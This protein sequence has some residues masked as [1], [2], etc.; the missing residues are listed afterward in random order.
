MKV[1]GEVIRFWNSWSLG[2]G[3]SV[4]K[5]MKSGFLSKIHESRGS[6]LKFMKVGGF[7]YEIREVLWSPILYLNFS[8]TCIL[9]WNWKSLGSFLKFMKVGVWTTLWDAKIRK[10]NRKSTIPVPVSTHI[11]SI[12]VGG[13]ILFQ[14]SGVCKFCREVGKGRFGPPWTARRIPNWRTHQHQ[15]CNTRDSCGPRRLDETHV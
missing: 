13:S 4:L 10:T 1:G 5:F 12:L 2:E 8:H 7:C 14:N 11:K 3:N 6:F 15:N 9:L